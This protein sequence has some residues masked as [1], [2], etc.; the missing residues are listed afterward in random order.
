MPPLDRIR[1]PAKALAWTS[2]SAAMLAGLGIDALR[3]AP[4]PRRGRLAVAVLAVAALAA[5]ALAPLAFP[6]RLAA[7]VGA[8]ATGLLAVAGEHPRAR[9]ALAGLAAAS[10]VAA[11]GLGLAGLPRFAPEAELRRDRKS[12]V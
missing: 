1:Y 9:A 11:L 7:G 6:V 8:A 2:F 4:A 10:V 12:V 5:A 3:F